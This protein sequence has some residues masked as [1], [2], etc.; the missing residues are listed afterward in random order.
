MHGGNS[1]GGLSHHQRGGGGEF[2]CHADDCDLKCVAKQVFPAA[3]ID[4]RGDS[5]QADANANCA[6]SPGAPMRVNDHHADIDAS[7]LFDLFTN[8]SRR[9]IGVF[10]KQ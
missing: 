10:R 6:I 5:A 4:H 7:F 3:F 2:I 1:F 8:I 9:L